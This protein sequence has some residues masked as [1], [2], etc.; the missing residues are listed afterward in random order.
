MSLSPSPLRVG[1]VVACVVAVMAGCTDAAPVRARVTPEAPATATDLVARPSHNSPVLAADPTEARFVVMANRVDNPEFG[2]ALQVSGDGGRGWIPATPVPELPAGAERCY[3]PEVAFDDEGKLYYLFV[4]LAGQGNQPTGVYL[5]T[6]T[7]RA[8]TFSPPQ[9]VLGPGNFMVRMA[10]DATMGP[11][12]RIHL[13]WLHTAVPPALGGFVGPENPILAAHSDDGGQTFSPPVQISAPGARAVAPAVALGP[14]HTLHIAYY[15]L[16]D[17]VR[18]YQGLEGPTWEGTWSLLVSSSAEGGGGFSPPVVVTDEIVPPGRVM[19]IF[20]MPAAAVAVGEKGAL[21]LAWPDARQGDPDIF[22]AR[23]PDGGRSWAPP[24]R[25]NDDPADNGRD[26]YLP[27]LAVS[28]EGRVDAIFYDR[29]DDPANL[30][31]DVYYTYST[32]GGLHF[33]PNLKVTSEPSDSRIGQRYLIASA[34]GLNDFGSRLGLLSGRSS[35]V[36]AWADTRNSRLGTP[37]QA[38]FSTEIVLR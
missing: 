31:N 29:R 13:V 19:L 6:S 16:Q 37:I 15:D 4:G 2:C 24:Q 32:D 28:P 25:L 27:R 5:T 3:S 35:A 30:K 12:G 11:V 21:L 26:Q 38:I 8:R 10:I 36:A 34:E 22:F 23:S 1:A 17:D 14:D 9:M 18:D 7:D 20:T 33:A